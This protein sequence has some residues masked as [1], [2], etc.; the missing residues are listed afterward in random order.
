MSLSQ[1]MELGPT[2]F[3]LQEPHLEN[4]LAETISDFKNENGEAAAEIDLRLEYDSVIPPKV[5]IDQDKMHQIVTNLLVNALGFTTAGNIQVKTK[6]LQQNQVFCFYW[7]RQFL[8]LFI[9]IFG[10]HGDDAAEL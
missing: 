3:T 5:Y 4:F 2:H 7:N 8:H 6:C 9:G 10:C 1:E